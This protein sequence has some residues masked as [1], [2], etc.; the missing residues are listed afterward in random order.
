MSDAPFRVELAPAA[1]RQLGKL[2]PNITARL[3]GPI[4]TL[5]G[6]PRPD[7]MTPLVGTPFCRARVGDLRFIYHVDDQAR[8][9]VI[10]R[11]ARRAESTYRRVR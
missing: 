5:A 1:E 10:L 6:N 4:L 7:G 3:R 9:V 11:V 2:P 8:I